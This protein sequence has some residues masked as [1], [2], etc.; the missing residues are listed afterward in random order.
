MIGPASTHNDYLTCV[1]CGQTVRRKRYYGHGVKAHGMFGGWSRLS[2]S[3]LPRRVSN[4][5]LECPYC[6]FRV[7]PKDL[8]AH[9][10]ST[11]KP[12]R[13]QPRIMQGGLVNPR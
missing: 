1:L 11:H 5:M 2:V 9:Q 13:R 10:M 4:G 3:K 7:L 6:K 12:D 8:K